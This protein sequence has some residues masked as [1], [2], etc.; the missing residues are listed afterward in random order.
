MVEKKNKII[1]RNYFFCVELIYISNLFKDVKSVFY[2]ISV[3]KTRKTGPKKFTTRV[4]KIFKKIH[5][6]FLDF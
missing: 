6:S 2:Y 3:N 4:V 1:T 5:E